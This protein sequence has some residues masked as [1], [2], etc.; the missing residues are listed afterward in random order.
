MTIDIDNKGK[1]AVKRDWDSRNVSYSELV[2]GAGVF[3]WNV[4]FDLS[5]TIPFKVEDQDGSSSCVG[6]A[7]AKY[8]E[9]LEFI[10]TGVYK[11]FSAKFLYSRIYIPPD[12]GAYIWK[13]AD[14]MKLLGDP[15][16][17]LDPSYENGT[18]PSEAY[19]RI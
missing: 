11:D 15:D 19:M 9:A 8:A 4:G 3:D 5:T 12:G 14:M 6:Q 10:E 18:P 17:P 13:G 16:E 2:A 1:G 7:W